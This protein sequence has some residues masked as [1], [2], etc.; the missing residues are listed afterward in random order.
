MK[1]RIKDLVIKDTDP[2]D[3]DGFFESRKKFILRITNF[4]KSI[5]DGLTVSIDSEWGTGKSTCL[6]AMEKHLKTD[7][8]IECIYFDAFKNDFHDDPFVAISSKMMEHFSDKNNFEFKEGTVR[9]AKKLLG[10]GLKGGITLLTSGAI[11][12]KGI[13]AACKDV[14]A[15]LSIQADGIIDEYFSQ[16]IEKEASTESLIRSLKKGLQALLKTKDEKTQKLVFIIDELD[17]CRP[18]YAIGILE[19][20]KH[21]F[22]MDGVIFIL[23][24]NKNQMINYVK[25]KYGIDDI[26]T[27]DQYLR[28]F[29]NIEF[30]LPME[31]TATGYA[32]D[33]S[34]FCNYL[35]VAHG[36]LEEERRSDSID[37]GSC[38]IYPF[39]H[40]IEDLSRA[41]KL[42][43][44]EIEDLF[45]LLIVYYSLLTKEP[46]VNHNLTLLLAII[47]IK[48]PELY[49]KIK[50]G[51]VLEKDMKFIK[52]LQLVGSD[53]K[54]LIEDFKS[55][56]VDSSTFQREPLE[57]VALENKLKS[58][59]GIKSPV[60]IEK[61]ISDACKDLDMFNSAYKG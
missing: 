22:S 31:E 11:N 18:D 40:Y 7:D 1:Y 47:K 15:G 58:T 56:F 21:F 10:V 25:G 3:S 29:I 16:Q 13:D 4:I 35:M 20:I 8:S 39:S 61:H 51:R 53:L 23:S 24:M 9:I 32:D 5:E 6:R 54:S 43:L 60:L 59:Y 44:R 17:R 27:A 19:R 55:L 38:N 50:I 30:N 2:L 37:F 52:G 48:N 33:Y 49:S 12:S 41:M 42:K 14:V 36:F 57:K 26:E 45:R 46:S 28:K 34:R